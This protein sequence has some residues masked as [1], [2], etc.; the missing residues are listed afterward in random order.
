M[1]KKVVTTNEIVEG[2]LTTPRTTLMDTQPDILNSMY[3]DILNAKKSIYMEF[4]RIA[5]D[6]TGE[7]FIDILAKKAKEGLKVICMFDSWGTPPAKPFFDPIIRN[8]GEVLFFRKIKFFV[9]FFTKNHRRNHRKLLIIDD[10]ISYIGSMNITGYSATWRELCL[11]I[12]GPI[13]LIFKKTFFESTKLRDK[14]IFNK[15]NYKKTIFYNGF[16]IVQD[17]PSIYRQMV[18]NRYEKFIAKATKEI[19]IETPYFMPGY[20][21][22]KFLYQAA[23]RGVEV[24]VIMPRH[25]DVKLVDLLRDKYLL[26]MHE[27]GINMQFYTSG[28]LHAKG[29]MVDKK[30][31]AIGSSNFDYRSFRYQHEIMLIGKQVEI[32][33][34]IDKHLKESLKGCQPFDPEAYR[35][36]SLIEK[37]F[38]WVLIPFRHLF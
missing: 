19:I 30:V 31:F 11:R 7:N 14:Y 1:E 17:L 16:E 22:R 8:G 34:M 20:K 12:E 2:D 26:K 25:S 21:L 36:R 32:V 3:Q 33:E 18:K 6:F 37:F 15:F 23:E 27:A 9:D 4:Y 38:G 24:I 10:E 35:R 5:F 28:N 29:V 13:A